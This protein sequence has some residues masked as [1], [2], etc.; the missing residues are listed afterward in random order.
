MN[1]RIHEYTNGSIAQFHR[2]FIKFITSFQSSVKHV[3]FY[4]SRLSYNFS[5]R[6]IFFLI[7]R[8]FPFSPF[9]SKGFGK[10]FYFEIEAF[11]VSFF[12]FY[13][14]RIRICYIQVLV[15]NK[16][17]SPRTTECRK[18]FDFYLRCNLDLERRGISRSKIYVFSREFFYFRIFMDNRFYFKV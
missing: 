5:P 3:F 15:V 8:N 6:E 9:W 18:S 13:I 14:Q 1:L 16:I 4:V 10:I 12:F 11:I 17:R 2:L 7:N